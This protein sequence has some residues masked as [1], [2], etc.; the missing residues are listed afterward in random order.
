MGKQQQ[1]GAVV[2]K[3]PVY[4]ELPQQTED[5]QLVAMASGMDAAFSCASGRCVCRARGLTH[6]LSASALPVAAIT[7]A[8]LWLS[9]EVAGRQGANDEA[10]FRAIFMDIVPRVYPAFLAFL[11]QSP[12]TVK[13]IATLSA[14]NRLTSFGRAAQAQLHLLALPSNDVLPLIWPASLQSSEVR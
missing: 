13:T 7:S 2:E 12:A 14:P 6:H 3:L 11:Q 4:F 8:H 10:A 5:V 9:R 1:S